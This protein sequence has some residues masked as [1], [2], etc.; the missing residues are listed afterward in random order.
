MLAYILRRLVM[1]VIVIVLI[2]V[3]LGALVN[4]IPGDPVQL[5]L[6]SPNPTPELVAQV[7]ADMHL[8]DP[9]P[10]QVWIFMSG[11]V[12]GD[13]GV[14]FRTHESV[15][16]LII[17]ALPATLTL[18]VASLLLAILVGIP[19]GVLSAVR[20]NSVADRTLSIVSIALITIPPYVAGLLLLII[21]AVRLQ[22]LPS[23][24]GG[25]LSDP[26]DYT[27]H[28]ILP[29]TALAVTWIGYIARLVRTSMLEVMNADYI[30]TARAYGVRESLVA[31][32]YALRNAIIPTIAVL[33]VAFGSL[34]GVAVFVEVIFARPGLGMLV[35][36]AIQARNY[37]VV[38]G[39]VLVIAILFVLAN[40]AADLMY[41]VVDPRIRVR[42][43][44]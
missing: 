29:V 41:Q 35:Y 31:Y 5:M 39:G 9:L 18:A 43:G 36:D 23:I 30:R 34:I 37:P 40:L 2:M 21:F 24:G 8:D 12:Q 4:L 7:R 25:D 42:S 11:A 10:T 38:R 22:V 6:R 3:F 13:L 32:K 1:T 20:P 33:G 16:D 26:A 27:L 19:L 15:T 28:L 44:S 14:D 17:Q